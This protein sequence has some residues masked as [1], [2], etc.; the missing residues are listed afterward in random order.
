V[1]R[2]HF[3]R[4]GVALDEELV[5]GEDGAVSLGPLHGVR[6]A[7]GQPQFR[8]AFGSHPSRRAKIMILPLFA[9]PKVGRYRYWRMLGHASRLT[10]GNLAQ[11]CE[12]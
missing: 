4:F 8:A 2:H 7:P 10:A 5:V 6:P 3:L 12:D 1:L 11:G 9:V